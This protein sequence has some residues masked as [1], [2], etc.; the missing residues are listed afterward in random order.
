MMTDAAREM[1]PAR[2]GLAMQG[3]ERYR[4]LPRS[5]Y[6]LIVIGGG[7]AGLSAA[8][9]A[10]TLGARVALLDR[11]R[12]GGECLYTGCV[13]SKALL[14]VAHVASHIRAA[15]ELGLDAR[16]APVDLGAVAEY[17]QRAIRTIRDQT[18][19][20]EHFQ[21]L[22]AD[23]GFGEVR[24]LSADRLALNGRSVRAKRFLICTGSRPSVPTIP[25]LEE[26][27]YQT[28][29]TI[30]ALRMLPA[31]LAVLGGGPV[32]CELGQAFARLGSQVTILQRA[33]QLLPR[34][35]PEAA[36][37]LRARLEAEGVT[38]VTHASVT[39]IAQP[40][41][42]KVVTFTSPQTPDTRGQPQ[43]V[44][45]DA[46]L[47][48]VGRSP[49]VAELDLDAAGVRYDP[50]TGI[51]VDRRLRTSNARIYAVGDVIGGYRFTHAA[52]LQARTAVRN[53][54][55]PGGTALDE[56][57]M[58]WATFTEPEVAHVGLTEEQARREHG[59][60]V[61]AFT[62]PLREVDRAV[63]D[64]A[65]AGFVKLVSAKDG[66]LLGAQIVGHLAGEYINELALALQRKL[67]LADLGATTHV[68]PTMA[69]A[70]Q[71]AAGGYTSAKL[72]R[73]R[74]LPLLRALRR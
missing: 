23:V 1:S 21:R 57:V 34:D 52:A 48:A 61:R 17:V 22:G 3:V 10:A 42:S 7:S 20:P 58:P 50:R 5:A 33:E 44:A 60:G 47:V 24:F 45:V 54:L 66:R 29:E 15:G 35:E 56:R 14:H 69:L 43:E 6:D 16:L 73:N 65:T 37:V 62:Q 41:G 63:T 27:G 74:L 46:L 18:D 8:E 11:E 36:A 70:I 67:T 71:Q 19:N 12:L 51:S 9:L 25:G 30:F 31:R 40:A 55:F 68:Y 28:N 53:A 39:G 64:G 72:R 26:A 38:V 49:N 32:G 13:P 59:A 2:D 4:A